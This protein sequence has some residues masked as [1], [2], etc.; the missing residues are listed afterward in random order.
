M[1]HLIAALALLL[2]SLHAGA[3]GTPPAAISDDRSFEASMAKTVGDLWRKADYAALDKMFDEAAATRARTYGGEWRL[4]MLMRSLSQ[5]LKIEWD[6]SLNIQGCKCH[7]PDPKNYALAGPRWD[8]VGAKAD[9]WVAKFPQ[10]PHAILAKSQY[11]INRGWFYR[12]SGFVNTVPEAAWPLYK[13]HTARARK[14]LESTR[15]LGAKSPIWFE[16]MFEIAATQS[17]SKSDRDE[18]V[19]DFLANGQDYFTAYGKAFERMRPEWGGSIAE[20][21]KFARV[22]AERTRKQDGAALYARLYWDVAY[23]YGAEV[24]KKTKPNWPVLR[25]G[26]EQLVAQ[27]PEKRNLNAYAYFG[28]VGIDAG[29]AYKA[30][31][32]MGTNNKDPDFWKYVDYDWCRAFSGVDAKP[33]K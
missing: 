29:M 22:A 27:Y 32:M 19:T 14:L 8:A 18:L 30:F 28:C 23:T 6:D 15:K 24:V 31:T 33:A 16:Q 21:D 3:Q 2:F 1:H 12:G 13:D 10:S 11:L 9:A 20:M 7:I 25:Q 5:V 4:T 17:W 26:F